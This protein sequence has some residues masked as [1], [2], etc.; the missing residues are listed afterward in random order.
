MFR[1]WWS[2]SGTRLESSGIYKC[3]RLD[4]SFVFK[5]H[6]AKCVKNIFEGKT[7]I[8]YAALINATKRS[9]ISEHLVNNSECGNNYED[10]RFKIVQQCSNVYDL[11]K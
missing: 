10:V 8:K 3:C 6:V 7:N 11:I 2:C 9:S 4:F 5:E 1:N